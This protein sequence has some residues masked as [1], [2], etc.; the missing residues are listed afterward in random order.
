[1]K[2]FLICSLITI[3]LCFLSHQE[4]MA[5]PIGP[6]NFDEIGGT[7]GTLIESKQVDIQGMIPPSADIGDA[8]NQVYHNATTGIY[9]YVETITP[10][11]D[12]ISEV[13]TAFLVSAFNNVAGYSFTE[14]STAGITLAS[15]D[16]DPDGT[17]DWSTVGWH[18]NET[19]TVF[20]QSLS[21]PGSGIYNVIDSPGGRYGSF[22]PSPVPEP[23]TMLLFGAGL[24]GMGLFGR[25]RSRKV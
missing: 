24:A 12:H 10:T 18:A 22:A 6:T 19:L 13:N 9:T 1:M 7:L 4:G 23:A 17:L 8:I 20:Y 16:L 3:S 11:I 2:R 21:A 5:I 15:L 14:A 25:K